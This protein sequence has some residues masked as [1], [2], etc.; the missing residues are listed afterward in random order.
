MKSSIFTLLTATCLAV[1]PNGPG[2]GLSFNQAGIST[3]VTI[4]TPIIFQNLKEFTIPDISFDGGKLQNL[5]IKVPEPVSYD[6][7]KLNLEHAGNDI[8]LIA[9]NLQAEL[10]CDFSYKF[11]ITVKGKAD[12][13]IKKMDLNLDIGL[14]TQPSKQD[15]LAPELDISNINVLINP[16]DIDIKLSGSL[17]S[18]IASV[19]IPLFK[20]TLIPLIVSS[21]EDQ[22]K[23]IVDT[24]LD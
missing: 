16:D 10:T 22:V 2:F 12:I 18:K 1:S 3:A 23:V 9:N 14:S 5:N 11:G 20:S 8:D 13:T 7:I 24:T 6:D 15:E 4:V 17:V 21:L 19:F